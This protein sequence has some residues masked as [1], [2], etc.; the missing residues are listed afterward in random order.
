MNVRITPALLHGAVTAP[1]SKSDAHRLLIAAAL[2]GDMDRVRGA[3]VSADITA[4]RACLTALLQGDRVLDCCDSGSTLRFLTPVAAAL[5]GGTL[6]GSAQL[7][8]RPIRPLLKVLRAQGCEVK[9]DALPFSV[10]GG[11][12]S[13]EYA[14]PGDISSQFVSGLLF[15]LPLLPGDSRIVLTTPL[16]S[17]GYVDMTVNTLGRFGIAVHETE[18]GYDVPGGQRYGLPAGNIWPEGDWSGAA[19]WYVAN[20]LGSKIE[21]DGVRDDSAQGDRAIAAL[22][23]ELPD[24]VDMRDIPDLLPVLS[25][26]ACAKKGETRFTHAERLRIKESDRLSA[27]ERLIRDLGG[28]AVCGE[29]ELTV[30]GKRL[31]GGTVDGMHDHRMVMAAAIA[32]TVAQ[33]PVTILGAEAADKSYPAFFED[34]RRLGGKWDVV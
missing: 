20:A 29:N 1:P 32:A 18:D 34:Y 30:R 6:T 4:T 28:D 8:A 14:L 24:E 13:G 26:L 23:R 22:C 15:A 11:M 10:G 5:G 27:S 16:Q 33:Q 2:A 19:F 12:H 7:A 25:V 31:R 17:R 21:I 9:G 3:G